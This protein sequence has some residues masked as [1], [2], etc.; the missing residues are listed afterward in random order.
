[1]CRRIASRG[2]KMTILAARDVYRPPVDRL[3][4]PRFAS[5]R[6]SRPADASTAV[7]ARLDMAGCTYTVTSVT[8]P[9][10]NGRANNTRSN[11]EQLNGEIGEWCLVCFWCFFSSRASGVD[12]NERQAGVLRLWD[13]SGEEDGRSRRF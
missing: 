7:C 5:R 12:V 11:I 2:G 6:H 4:M 3:R 1:M 9:G 8:R 13:L 10:R